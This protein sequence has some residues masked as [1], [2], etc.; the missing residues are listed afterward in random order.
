MELT[1]RFRRLIKQREEEYQ[2]VVNR[3][4]TEYLEESDLLRDRD[5]LVLLWTSGFYEKSPAL[6]SHSER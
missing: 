6:L 2:L 1:N 5:K 4:E 3:F